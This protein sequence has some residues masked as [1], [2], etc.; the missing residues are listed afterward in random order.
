MRMRKRPVWPHRDKKP[1]AICPFHSASATRP[2]Q[3]EAIEPL[4]RPFHNEGKYA[5]IGFIMHIT[6]MCSSYSSNNR[7]TKP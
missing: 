1:S 7:Q 3:H 5:A 2:H 6:S 4:C